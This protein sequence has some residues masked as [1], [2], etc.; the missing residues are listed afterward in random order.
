[1]VDTERAPVGEVTLAAAIFDAPVRQH[2]LQAMVVRQQARHRRG[3]ASTKTRGEVAGSNKKP[4]RQKGTGRA[5]AGSRTSPIWRG[6]GIVFGPKPH[7]YDRGMNK[8]ERRQALCAALTLKRRE[9]RLLILERFSVEAIKT[10][11][12]KALLEKLNLSNVLIVVAEPDERLFLSARNLPGVKVL[13]SAGINVRDVLS[14][15]DLVLTR[16]AVDKIQEALA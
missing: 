7:D 5:R 10:K 3:T 13:V 15:Q 14:H 2:L 1:M 6:G 16:A 11:A 12:L 9:G 8:K 4:W